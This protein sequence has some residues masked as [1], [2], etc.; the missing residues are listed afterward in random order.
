MD[1]EAAV[2]GLREVPPPVHAAA[3]APPER[4]VGDEAA[5]RAE[6]ARL[7][8]RVRPPAAG[9]QTRRTQVSFTPDGADT[10]TIVIEYWG[11][12]GQL[13]SERRITRSPR[14]IAAD[15][16]AWRADEERQVAEHLPPEAESSRQAA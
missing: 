9:E 3:L 13:Q 11:A 16:A 4:G 15:V 2:V 6:I 7:G 14:N 10:S 8:V 5:F 1:A 12:D